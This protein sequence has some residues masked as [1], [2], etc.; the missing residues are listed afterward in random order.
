ME[1]ISVIIE[2]FG[3][4]KTEAKLYLALLSAGES[5]VNTLVKKT[6][7][8]RRLAYDSLG[9]L[10]KRGLVSWVGKNHKKYYLPVNPSKFLELSKEKRDAISRTE[11]QFKRLLPDLEA[12]FKAEKTER[13]IILLEGKEGLKT[14]INNQLNVGK[15]IHVIAGSGEVFEY[16]KY[17]MP[18]FV[19]RRAKQNMRAKILLNE[20]ARNK[21][22]DLPLTNIKYIPRK[23]YTPITISV[24]GDTVNLSIYSLEPL[25][26]LIRSKEIAQ[27]FMN[28]FNLMWNIAKK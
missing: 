13:E 2:K 24:Y 18:Q 27:S 20:D 12:R 7:A 17:F 4:S 3:L 28:Y 14:A 6:A 25:A 5:T 8:D 1:E 19:K 15:T 26:V 11:E 16:L 10:A 21:K 23:Y 22:I 9:K